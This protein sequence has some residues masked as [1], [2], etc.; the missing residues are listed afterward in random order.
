MPPGSEVT[1]GWVSGTA[2]ASGK[3]A[4]GA[5]S[6]VRDAIRTLVLRSAPVPR[7]RTYQRVPTFAGMAQIPVLLTRSGFFDRS[8]RNLTPPRRIER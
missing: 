6:A 4:M 2:A 7:R 1:G 5:L 3:W 8:T